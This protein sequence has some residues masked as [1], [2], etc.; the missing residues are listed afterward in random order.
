MRRQH[1]AVVLQ[2][3][4]AAIIPFR[5][6]PLA[7]EPR[8]VDRFRRQVEIE[9]QLRRRLSAAPPDR[10][11][12]Q[13]VGRLARILVLGIVG[14]AINVHHLRHRQDLLEPVED[15][16]IP[17]VGSVVPLA[18]RKA[19]SRVRRIRLGVVRDIILILRYLGEVAGPAIA[20]QRTR[21]HWAISG[22]RAF[23]QRVLAD[24]RKPQ[25][26]SWRRCG[27]QQREHDLFDLAF[28]ARQWPLRPGRCHRRRKSC[29]G[30][31]QSRKTGG[32]HGGRGTDAT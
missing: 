29:V 2:I 3:D 10:Q 15:E 17:L 13:I 28:H 6:Q 32:D 27:A 21:Q 20:P 23:R 19:L 5:V 8:G 30:A 4:A 7:V 11:L 9:L 31:G 24:Q 14:G 25:I 12:L 26:P 22:R 1:A 16:R 18:G